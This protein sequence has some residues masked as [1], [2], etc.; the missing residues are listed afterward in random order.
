MTTAEGAVALDAALYEALDS[1]SAALQA[2]PPSL[3]E[4]ESGSRMAVKRI[5][6][7]VSKFVSR[8]ARAIKNGIGHSRSTPAESRE[9]GTLGA[10][11]W[12]NLPSCSVRPETKADLNFVMDRLNWELLQEDMLATS[13][14]ISEFLEAYPD[15]FGSL[16]PRWERFCTSL[17][18]LKWQS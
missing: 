5:Y 3:E 17:Q 18:C 9:S 11:A 4:S 15:L 13:Q 7:R 10:S 2:L 1:V 6:G 8:V 14:G 12:E 16:T